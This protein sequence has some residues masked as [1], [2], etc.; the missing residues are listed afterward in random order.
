LIDFKLNRGVYCRGG[1]VRGRVTR[2]RKT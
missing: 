2:A 1:H